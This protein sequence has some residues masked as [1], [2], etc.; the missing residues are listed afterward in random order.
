MLLKH[1]SD[2]Y[3][4]RV[5]FYSIKFLFLL[6]FVCLGTSVQCA[7]NFTLSENRNIA[8][9]DVNTTL[10]FCFVIPLTP[11]HTCNLNNI[12]LVNSTENYVI[13]LGYLAINNWTSVNLNNRA[14]NTLE[15]EA[16]EPSVYNVFYANFYSL[17]KYSS[18]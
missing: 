17:S 5:Y 15:C 7:A 4:L 14:V 12:P 9:I 2:C 10:S 1:A 18:L 16:G 6:C 13:N 3:G 11:V 8:E